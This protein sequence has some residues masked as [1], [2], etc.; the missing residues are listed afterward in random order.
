MSA[1]GKARVAATMRN[2]QPPSWSMHP[3]DHYQHFLDYVH[4]MLQKDFAVDPEGA[5]ATF[6]RP[7]TWALRDKKMALKRRAR[8]RS[9]FW[10]PACL[11]TCSHAP[12]SS[13]PRMRTMA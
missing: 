7:D 4:A 8:H 5:K 1:E 6:I 13:G 9:H 2:Y 3:T 10:Q 11:K 12:S